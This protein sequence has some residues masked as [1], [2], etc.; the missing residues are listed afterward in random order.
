MGTEPQNPLP[1]DANNDEDLANSFADFFQS[2][3][4]KIHEMF[5]G[6]EAYN[7]E[8]NGTPNYASLHQ[9]LNLKLRPLQ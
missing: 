5:V 8:R 2:K 7:S 6:T 9:W 4:K 1:K 3:T